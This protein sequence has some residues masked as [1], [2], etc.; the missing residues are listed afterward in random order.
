VGRQIPD[1]AEEEAQSE[2]SEWEL[3]EQE[4]AEE[5]N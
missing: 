2:M 1:P 3:Q 5:R 4:K